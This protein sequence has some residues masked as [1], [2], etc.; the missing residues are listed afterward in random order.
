MMHILR[1]PYRIMR[2]AISIRAFDSHTQ[3]WHSDRI[4]I[5]HALLQW[6]VGA[7]LAAETILQILAW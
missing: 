6:T 4:D 7:A 1:L 3:V 5:D 2:I